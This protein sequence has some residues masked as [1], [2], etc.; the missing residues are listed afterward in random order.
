METE[1]E[2]WTVERQ[3]DGTGVI[4]ELVSRRVI[5]HCQYLADA[6]TIVCQHEEIERLHGVIRNIHTPVNQ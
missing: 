4:T 5:A 1:P 3:K 6:I 2:I